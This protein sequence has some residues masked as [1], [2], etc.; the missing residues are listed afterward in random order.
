MTLRIAIR[1]ED[2]DK[3]GEQRVAL[4]PPFVQA[5]TEAG[6]KVWVQP[7]WHPQLKINKRAIPDQAFAEAGAQIREDIQGADLILGIKEI[8]AEHLQAGAVHL[9]FSHTH[10]GQTKNRPLLKAMCDQHITLVDYERMAH[11]NGA[12]VITAFTYMAGYAGLIDSLWTLSKRWTLQGLAHPFG[13]MRQSVR[14]ASLEAAKA[15]LRQI[16]DTIR[17]DGTP[18]SRPPLLTVFLGNGR[19]SQGAREMYDLLPLTYLDPTQPLPPLEKLSRKQ[20][21]GLVLDVPQMYRLSPH[22]PWKREELSDAAFFQHYLKD[23][24][25]FESNLESYWGASTLLM[26]C[27]IWAPRFPRLVSYQQAQDWYAQSP[28]LEVI[29]DITCDPEGAIEFSRETWIDDP[30]FIYDPAARA[31]QSG[32]EG[33]GIAV[34]AVTN[35][36]CE[37]SA[38]ASTRF[39]QDLAPFLP[40]LLQADWSASQ[41]KKAHLPPEI[42]RAVILWKGTFTEPYSYMKDYLPE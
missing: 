39:A 19:T 4:T 28:T 35:L 25:Y 30:V 22:A 23:P 40:G 12:R 38:D 3:R 24:Q 27:I 18:E 10:K 41:L 42:E 9:F 31:F 2:P 37:F 14:Y 34:M 20:V 7:G 1:R 13:Q 5:L 11:E 15:A 16:G 17:Q 36:P 33:N 6:H 32:F 26:N 21:Y 29:G 8:K